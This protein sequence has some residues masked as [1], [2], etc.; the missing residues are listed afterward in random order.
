[1]PTP[2]RLMSPP[3][4]RFLR[5]HRNRPL[6]P[7][8][9]ARATS[10]LLQDLAALLDGIGRELADPAWHDVATEL[11]RAALALRRLA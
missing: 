4:Y 8:S 5:D 2:H 7:R 3:S 1:M 9:I 6:Q 11:D 10:A